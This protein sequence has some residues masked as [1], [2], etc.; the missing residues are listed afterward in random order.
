MGIYDDREWKRLSVECRA[1][2]FAFFAVDGYR[3]ERER[4][5]AKQE[6]EVKA[7]L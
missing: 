3:L 2:W 7:R 1:G 5:V 4:E 6:A